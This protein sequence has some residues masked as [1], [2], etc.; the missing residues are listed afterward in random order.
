MINRYWRGIRIRI[1]RGTT[2]KSKKR[3]GK[4]KKREKKR[5]RVHTFRNGTFV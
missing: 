5:E 2:R 1:S 3:K 4:E